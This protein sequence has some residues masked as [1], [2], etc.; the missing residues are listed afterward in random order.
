MLTKS[1][2]FYL[3][4]S[5]I[6]IFIKDIYNNY[7]SSTENKHVAMEYGTKADYTNSLT[8]G[9]NVGQGKTTSKISSS[10]YN[11]TIINAN[12]GNITLV[13][14]NNDINIKG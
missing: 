13:T 2:S 3:I 1:V 11:N 14:N 6:I 10:I 7:N 8:M 5:E 4:I 9:L 12:N